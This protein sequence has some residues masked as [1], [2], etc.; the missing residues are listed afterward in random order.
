MNLNKNINKI[1]LNK[2]MKLIIIIIKWIWI[3]K[4]NEM[5]KYMK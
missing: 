5:N 3:I 2:Y 1:N 4:W